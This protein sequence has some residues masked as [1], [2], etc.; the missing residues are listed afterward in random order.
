[1]QSFIISYF[2]KKYGARKFIEML[3]EQYIPDQHLQSF[4]KRKINPDAISA[5]VEA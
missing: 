4:P 5:R 3:I 1:M 2:I